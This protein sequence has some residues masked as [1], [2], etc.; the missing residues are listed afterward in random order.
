MYLVNNDD[1][2][3]TTITIHCNAYN[4]L[5]TSCTVWSVKNKATEI[6]VNATI[7][8]W[9]IIGGIYVERMLKEYVDTWLKISESCSP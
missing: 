2:L 3:M 1:G 8:M 9:S 6:L 4:I 5:R 7:S